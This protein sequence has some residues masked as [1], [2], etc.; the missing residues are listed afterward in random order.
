MDGILDGKE[1][2]GGQEEGW[3][4]DSLSGQNRGH[5]I[6]ERSPNLHSRRAGDAG[7]PQQ[8][9]LMGQSSSGAKNCKSSR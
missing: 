7:E 8:P 9:T 4:P 5:G 2:G 3:L 1:D 6:R